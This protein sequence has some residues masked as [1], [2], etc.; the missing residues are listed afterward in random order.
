MADYEEH[1]I[2]DLTIRIDKN[3]CISTGNCIK[4]APDV[5]RFDEE[6]IVAFTN[7]PEEADLSGEDR[8]RIVDSCRLCPVDA[9][10]VT[11]SDGDQ[12]VPDY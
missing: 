10:I 8:L 12:L 3:M 2:G 4:L 6:K 11:D 5:F 9:L 7:G 1:Q